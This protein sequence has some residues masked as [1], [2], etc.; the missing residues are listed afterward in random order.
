MKS[1]CFGTIT[2]KVDEREHSLEMQ[3]PYL[4]YILRQKKLLEE[5]QVVPIMV[6][7]LGNT[8]ELDIQC[9]EAL[10]PFF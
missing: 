2:K 1:P 4:A 5:I 8:E 6:G 7:E 9:A 10:Q 3:F